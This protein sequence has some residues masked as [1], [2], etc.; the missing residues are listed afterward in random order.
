M[1]GLS[2]GA[3]QPL[4]DVEEEDPTKEMRNSCHCGS[5]KSRRR[6]EKKGASDQEE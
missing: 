4:E 3:C 6:Q 5:K 2:P 1:Q